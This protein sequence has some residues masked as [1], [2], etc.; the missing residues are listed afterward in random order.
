MRY[1]AKSV[2]F[3]ERCKDVD[4]LSDVPAGLMGGYR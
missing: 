2:C 4:Q 3:R 1:E